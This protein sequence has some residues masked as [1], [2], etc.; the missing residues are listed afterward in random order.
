MLVLY[1]AM[2]GAIAAPGSSGNFWRAGR[3]RSG[4]LWSWTPVSRGSPAGRISSHIIRGQSAALS[5]GP[6]D[7]DCSDEANMTHD[8]CI[9][10]PVL[11]TS[12]H[13]ALQVGQIATSNPKKGAVFGCGSRFQ[14]GICKSPGLRPCY[15]G[16]V[17]LPRYR[18]SRNMATEKRVFVTSLLK[19]MPELW[20]NVLSRLHNTS[21][22][23]CV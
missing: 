6:L 8:E 21:V 14:S 23:V 10:F 19:M 17:V 11:R 2:S 9:P 18:V 12:C 15:G 22:T 5:C 7:P 13:R 1:S 20:F 4:R 16:M 3:I